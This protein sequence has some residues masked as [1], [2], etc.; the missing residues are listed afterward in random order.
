MI[1]TILFNHI[2]TTYYLATNLATSITHHLATSYTTITHWESFAVPTS[3]RCQPRTLQHSLKL[4]VGSDA[5]GGAPAGPGLIH[6][7]ARR[8]IGHRLMVNHWRF[9]FG[10]GGGSTW[11]NT[12]EPCQC[13]VSNKRAIRP[14]INGVFLCLHAERSL[15]ALLHPG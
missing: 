11:I 14:T 4:E 7:G 2:T 15:A 1:E 9:R 3:P 6:H 12:S 10:T 8:S 13:S 5:A